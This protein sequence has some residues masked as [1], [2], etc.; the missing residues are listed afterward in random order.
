MKLLRRLSSK[1]VQRRFISYQDAKPFESIPGPKTLPWIGTGYY[2]LNGSD[3]KMDLSRELFTKWH[4]EHGSI[5]RVKQFGQNIV[6]VI[7]PE[8]IG[9]SIKKYL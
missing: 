4:Q 6:Y 1:Q 8:D 7:E 5:V 9:K 3:K 2:L